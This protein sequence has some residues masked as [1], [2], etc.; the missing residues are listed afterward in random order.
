MIVGVKHY[1]ALLE[2]CKERQMKNETINYD[3][4]EWE[5][6]TYNAFRD[7]AFPGVEIKLYLRPLPAKPV[8]LEEEYIQK[9]IK[10]TWLSQPDVQAACR[11]MDRRLD[12]LSDRLK[13]LEEK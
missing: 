5:V 11:F 12:E 8:S 3:G 6:V 13:K 4:R 10:E 7:P 2:V 9:C 1:E